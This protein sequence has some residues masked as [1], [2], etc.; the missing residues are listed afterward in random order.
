MSNLRNVFYIAH[1]VAPDYHSGSNV[2]KARRWWSWLS[3]NDRTRV[4]IAPWIVEVEQ[5]IRQRVQTNYEQALLDDMEVVRRCDGIILCGPKISSGMQ[6]ELD[7]ATECGL[8]VIDITGVYAPYYH[9]GT[10]SAVL[11]KNLDLIKKMLN[12]KRRDNA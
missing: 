1:P 9:N 4:Y 2:A 6:K 7:C 10:E 11:R 12:Y 8:E 5:C 3:Q